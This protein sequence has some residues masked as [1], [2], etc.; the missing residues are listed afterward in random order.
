MRPRFRVTPLRGLFGALAVVVVVVAGAGALGAGHGDLRVVWSDE[1][2]GR[3]GVVPDDGKWRLETIGQSS[4]NGE[5]QCYTDAADNAATDGDGHL[6]IT[7]HRD[8]GHVC[9]DGSQNDFTSARL[10]TLDVHDWQH[11][12]FEVKARV[13]A[14]VGTW[15]AFWSLG[16]DYP[17]VGW[18]E[19]GELDVMEVIGADINHLIGTAHFPDD[20]GERV[21]LQ[22][23]ADVSSPLS[24]AFHVYAMEWDDE[25]IVWSL[26]GEE[27][28][29]VGR[30]EVEEAGDWVFDD[31]FYLVLN[32]AIGGVLGGP[33]GLDT[34][35][36]QR[37]VVDYVRVYQ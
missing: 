31:E 30:D 32:L 27:Y 23:S 3:A 1:F 22:A 29:S 33:V 16:E 35:F 24:D 7:A 9:S 4:G 25:R 8:P 14:G 26:D 17:D 13:P 12:R 21:F 18:P 19:S 36:P 28:G 5:L 34:E 2:D 20:E 37:F 11:G 6:V 10:T 15:P